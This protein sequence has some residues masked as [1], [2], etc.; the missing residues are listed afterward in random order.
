MV[1]CGLRILECGMRCLR[2]KATKLCGAR[3]M[4]YGAKSTGCGAEGRRLGHRVGG[5]RVRARTR[6]KKYQSGNIIRLTSYEL[7]AMK[8]M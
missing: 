2:V 4:K 8:Q 5:W 1:E 6:L 3:S 7:R